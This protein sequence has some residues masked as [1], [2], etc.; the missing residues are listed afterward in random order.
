MSVLKAVLR[1]KHSWGSLSLFHISN[2]LRT[3]LWWPFVHIKNLQSTEEAGFILQTIATNPLGPVCIDCPDCGPAK[4][5]PSTVMADDGA[6]CI[7]IYERLAS[8]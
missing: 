4:S 3:Q 7:Y 5:G 1:Q 8:G 6:G 2:T